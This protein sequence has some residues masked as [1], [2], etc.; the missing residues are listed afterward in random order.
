MERSE[1]KG[2]KAALVV[3]RLFGVDFHQVDSGESDEDDG[4]VMKLKKCSSMPNDLTSIDPAVH[5][6]TTSS[7]NTLRPEQKLTNQTDSFDR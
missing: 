3:I 1:E 7:C 5:S 2:R 6:V 4:G